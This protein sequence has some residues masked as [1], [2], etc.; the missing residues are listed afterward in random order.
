MKQ[1][2]MAVLIAA[3]AL[4][5]ARLLSAMRFPGPSQAVLPAGVTPPQLQGVGVDEHL[6]RPVDLNLTFIAENG[7]PVALK[8]FFHK[9]KPVILD[10]IYYPCPNAV[11]PDSQRPGRR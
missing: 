6:G 5:R 8:D 7:Y 11:R 9:G 1:K 4:T 3:L 2:L 10:L